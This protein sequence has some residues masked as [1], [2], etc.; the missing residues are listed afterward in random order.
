MNDERIHLDPA[1]QAVQNRLSKLRQTPVDTSRLEARL[2][3]TLA[4]EMASAPRLRPA[5]AGRI[6]VIRRALALAAMVTIITGAAAILL[7]VGQTPAIA[8][9][10]D[11]VRVHRSFMDRAH[12]NTHVE[13]TDQANR[14]IA[15]LW[16][17]APKVPAPA[18]DP[19]SACCVEMVNKTPVACVHLEH[20][21]KAV[22]MVVAN[23]SQMHCP[24]GVPV[25]YDGHTFQVHQS[26]G[27]TMVMTMRADRC[28][29]LVSELDSE[30]LLK[31]ASQL[32]FN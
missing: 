15:D 8:S 31:L 27:L 21:G 3:A 32:R 5:I 28:V 23:A 12:P 19:I 11:L 4:A 10:N 26:E 18:A 17:E 14:V 20:Q 13:T 25:T 29:C 30:T 16:P 24:P 7:T 22:T 6:M 2:H 9:P 1:D